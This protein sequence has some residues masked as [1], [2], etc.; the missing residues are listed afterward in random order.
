[1]ARTRKKVLYKEKAQCLHPCCTA[2]GSSK[3]CEPHPHNEE[4]C[5]KDV[6]GTPGR[7]SSCDIVRVWKN[8]FVTYTRNP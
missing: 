3:H 2:R 6:C 7:P 8:G 1:M 5:S 4:G